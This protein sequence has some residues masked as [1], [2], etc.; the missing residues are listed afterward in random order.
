MRLFCHCLVIA[1]AQCACLTG[2]SQNTVILL[3]KNFLLTLLHYVTFDTFVGSRVSQIAGTLY[4]MQTRQ[5]VLH[6]NKRENKIK[7]IL[8]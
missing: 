4:T 1:L 6:L 8:K 7:N 2:N 3:R 5:V